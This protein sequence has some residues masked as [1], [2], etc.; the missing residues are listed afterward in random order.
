MKTPPILLGAVLVFWGWQAGFLIP[1]VIMGLV[2]EAARLIKARWDFSDDDFSR[3]WFFCCLVL[4]GAVVFA[5]ST[6]EGPTD[7]RGLFHGSNWMDQRNAGLATAR[8]AISVLRW[9]PIIVFLFAAAQ[10][11]GSREE[12]PLHAISFILRHRLKNARRLG[13]PLPLNRTFN[14]GYPFFALCLFSASV[15]TADDTVFFW[16][17]CALTGWA[18]WPHRSARYA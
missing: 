2:I 7:L 16:G 4:L 1:G 11:Y 6:N 10:A 13:L 5:F 12:I 18:L 15:H 8:T 9:L 17:F 3:I 14:I